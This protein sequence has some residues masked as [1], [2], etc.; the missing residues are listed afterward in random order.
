MKYTWNRLLLTVA[1]GLLC[2]AC[3]CHQA[4]LGNP[5]LLEK[6]A[7]A[8]AA[9]LA[10]LVDMR[11]GQFGG[12]N[13]VIGPQ[14]P[15]GSANP[16]PQTPRGGHDGYAPGQPVRGF[17]QLHVTG[18]GWGC[19]GQMLLSPQV[20]LA[21]GEDEHDSPIADEQPKA[22]AYGC[23]LSRYGIRVDLAPAHD[24]AVYRIRLP[25]DGNCHLVLDVGHSIAQHIAT[26]MGGHFHGGTVTFAKDGRLLLADGTY[27]GGFGN[28][29]YQ[30]FAA[31]AIDVPSTGHGTWTGAGIQTGAD[32]QS[33]ADRLGAYWRI[34]GTATREATVR[35]GI[36]LQSSA[37]AQ[38][39]LAQVDAGYETVASRARAAWN[40]VLS[41]VT[42]EGGTDNERRLFTT[43]LYQ[44]H[45]MPRNRTNDHGTGA[46]WWDDH[47]AAWDT[48]YTKMPL[49]AIID[50]PAL[51]GI[52]NSFAGRRAAGGTVADAFV[53]GKDS[54]NQGGD[55]PD[56]IIA[57]AWAKKITGIDWPAAFEV[58]RYH[59]ESGRQPEYRKRGWIPAGQMS[60][61]RTLACAYNDDCAARVAEGLGRPAEAAR[62]RERSLGWRQLWNPA[63]THDGFSG[64]VVPR[65]A[66][67]AWVEPFDVAKPWGSWVDYFYEGTAWEY[68]LTP[69]HDLPWLIEACG[70]RQRFLERVEHAVQARLAD[71]ANEP[72]FRTPFLPALLGDWERSCRLV[73][74][75][76]DLYQL[77]KGYPGNEDSGAMASWYVFTSIGFFPLAGEDCYVVTTPAFARMT[78]RMPDGHTL[79]IERGPRLAVDGVPAAEPGILRHAQLMTARTITIP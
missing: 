50:P 42:V 19:Y 47:Y 78:I 61:S 73:R 54:C 6:G 23:T 20:G 18:T 43:A 24:A 79:A 44:S 64:F 4:G 17:G 35:I 51:A 45:L 28:G 36:S 55:E 66:S 57:D 37:M 48:W 3:R 60:C 25:A 69:L 2:Q 38:R 77:D 52:V 76:R 29:R 40:T 8:K 11:M 65:Q 26:K 21:T 39:H 62:W 41:R 16:S 75:V 9:V 72:S 49:Y 15:N 58:L 12:S 68:T 63:A 31:I 71:P 10:D 33:A 34:D 56:N 59:A 7:R 53:F 30:V 1:A 67:G 32:T 27:S 74:K 22:Y 46:I 14:L 5:A 13:C 70:G